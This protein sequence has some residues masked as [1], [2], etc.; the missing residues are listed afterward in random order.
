VSFQ[1]VDSE[2]P[3]QFQTMGAIIAGVVAGVILIISALGLWY[4]G[5]FKRKDP[6]ERAKEE[7]MGETGFENGEESSKMLNGN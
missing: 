5:F 6:K 3:E 4:C 7:G 2:P 1:F